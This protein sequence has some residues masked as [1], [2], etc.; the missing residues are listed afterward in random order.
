[1]IKKNDT[2]QEHFWAGAQVRRA[3]SKI[4]R[5]Y[6]LVRR[7]DAIRMACVLLAAADRPKMHAPPP[8][9]D[10]PQVGRPKGRRGR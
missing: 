5:C 4:C 10:R 2:V 9:L 7:A 8:P 1:M 6:G 3:I